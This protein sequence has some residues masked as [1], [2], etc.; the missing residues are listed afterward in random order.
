MGEPYDETHLRKHVY[1][2]YKT[3]RIKYSLEF[4][5]TFLIFIF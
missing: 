3:I 1:D 5:F 4:L 2:D